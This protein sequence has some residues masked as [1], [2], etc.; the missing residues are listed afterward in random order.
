M[1][2][3]RIILIIIC[4]LRS[5]KFGSPYS[6]GICG[7]LWNIFIKFPVRS[8]IHIHHKPPNIE[9]VN[10]AFVN[11]RTIV[12]LKPDDIQDQMDKVKS[13]MDKTKWQI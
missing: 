3:N 10:E 11:K 7:N 13:K 6:L 9:K 2:L 1:N 8:N 12:Y 4:E 5:F